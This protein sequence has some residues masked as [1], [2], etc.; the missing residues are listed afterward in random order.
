M[1]EGLYVNKAYDPFIGWLNM[2]EL[3][4][5]FDSLLLFII[6]KFDPIIVLLLICSTDI[7]IGEKGI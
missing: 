2:L 4:M 6:E 1:V 3:G 7:Y 5:D